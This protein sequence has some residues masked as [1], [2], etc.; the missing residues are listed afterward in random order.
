MCLIWL[1]ILI[2][3]LYSSGVWLGVTNNNIYQNTMCSKEIGLHAQNMT[4]ILG[5]IVNLIGGTCMTIQRAQE[6]LL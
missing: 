2:G 6:Y 3:H 1:S 5:F 4:T